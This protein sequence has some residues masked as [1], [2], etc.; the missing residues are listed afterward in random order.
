MLGVYHNHRH[1]VGG[2]R[3]ERAAVYGVKHLVGV[4]VVGGDD[5]LAAVLDD[6]VHHAAGALVHGLDGLD[7]RF[8]HARVA[9]HVAVG[10]VEDDD[11][12]LLLVDALDDRVGHLV[13]AHLGLQVKR[14][15]FLRGRGRNQNSV[16]AGE[17]ALLAAVEEER[18]VR[19]LLR[20]GNAQLRLAHLGKVLA[21]GHVQRLRRIGQQHVR[22][23]RVVLGHA[24]IRQREEAALAR[25][26]LEVGIYEG[27]GNLAGAVGA[28]VEEHHRIVGLHHAVF[29][30]DGGQH[31]FVGQVLARL[32]HHLV[33]ILDGLHRVGSLNAL[34]KHH[35]VVGF[36]HALPGVVAVHGVET[37][38]HGGHLAH[39]QLVHLV[40][41]F[42]HVLPAGIRRHVAA[43]EQAVHVHFFKAVALGH[44]QQAVEV[45]GVRM[46]TAGRHQ[47]N[48]VQRGIVLLAILH[49][50]QQRLV[51]K[52]HAI[53][54]VLGDLHQHLVDHAARADVGVAHLAVAHLPVRQAHVQA[55]SADGGRAVFRLETVDVG[56]ARGDDGV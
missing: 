23:R 16:L 24:H 27:A 1:R 21:H 9:H 12:V 38:H 54:D 34:A 39:A 37:A 25:K 31:E 52:E 22:H 46:H 14:R 47:A 33:G 48:Q 40:H 36:F 41:Q 26:A 53:L 42:L 11:V 56:R 4:A 10:E 28:E 50:G 30:N 51:F 49:R 17:H 6:L 8:H 45:P 3:G 44:L 7:G 35:G 20:F 55:G 5:A 18:H 43:V 29:V 15:H 13:G 32:V 2:V 19:V